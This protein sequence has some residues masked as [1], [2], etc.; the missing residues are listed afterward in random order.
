MH[1]AAPLH[2]IVLSDAR[3]VLCELR[4]NR[5]FGYLPAFVSASPEPEHPLVADIKRVRDV[6]R[7]GLRGR[8]HSVLAP[9]ALA[10]ALDPFL[11]IVQSR[12]TSGNITG[13]ALHSIDCIA[14]AVLALPAHILPDYT[15]VLSSIFSCFAPLRMRP[16]SRS[17]AESSVVISCGKVDYDKSG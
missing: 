10:V 1:S 4:G 9:D 17:W 7:F 8:P 6:V 15:P 16:L 5:R 13:V 11:R 12:D 3:D 2:V 14:A